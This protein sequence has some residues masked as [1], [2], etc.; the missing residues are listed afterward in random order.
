MKALFL[1]GDGE[2][3]NVGKETD[4]YQQPIDDPRVDP[5]LPVLSGDQAV[6]FHR[7]LSVAA[8]GY[9]RGPSRASGFISL[10]STGNNQSFDWKNESE[11]IVKTCGRTTSAMPLLIRDRENNHRMSLV[12]G[13][14]GQTIRR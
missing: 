10:D 5:L 3:S 12:A 1:D 6:T 14:E 9:S 4:S 11:R 2:L 7:V 13:I 8:T